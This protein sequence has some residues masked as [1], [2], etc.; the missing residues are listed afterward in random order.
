MHPLRA[1]LYCRV[2]HEIGLGAHVGVSLG[3]GNGAT[4]DLC[5]VSSFLCRLWSHNL[6]RCAGLVV[7]PETVHEVTRELCRLFLRVEPAIRLPIKPSDE[8]DKYFF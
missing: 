4:H 6:A 1:V 5:H 7:V 2:L 3:G 8:N